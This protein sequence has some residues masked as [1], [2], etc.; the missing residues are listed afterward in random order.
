MGTWFLPIAAV[1]AGVISFTSPCCLPLVPGYL[2]YVSG[3]PVG[4]LDEHTA[5]R[6]VLTASILFVAGFTVVFTALGVSFALVGSALTR[7]VPTILRFAGVGIIVAGVSMTGLVRIP[8]LLR[9]VRVDLAR[10]PSGPASAFPMGAAFAFGWVPCIGPVLATIL[11]TASASGT[12]GWGAVLLVC[13]SLG[14]GLPFIALALGYQRGRRSLMWLRRHSRAM[15]RVGGVLL[16]VVG[17][18]FLTGQWQPLFR[19]LQRNF[20]RFGWPPI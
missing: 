1:V 13:Y 9:E 16:I 14:L 19:P 11:T 20:A 18:L 12:V 2:S 5:R 4:E 15:E 8:L 7:N 10:L 6:R 17:V 3:L